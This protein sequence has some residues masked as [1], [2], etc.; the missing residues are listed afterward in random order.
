MDI[1][2]DTKRNHR[3]AHK[4]RSL[5]FSR[6]SMDPNGTP[7]VR[8]EGPLGLNGPTHGITMAP[9]WYSNGTH[10]NISMAPTLG[11]QWPPWAPI[12]DF[13]DRLCFCNAFVLGKSLFL[14]TPDI[15]VAVSKIAIGLAKRRILAINCSNYNFK[16]TDIQFFKK[17]KLKK[18]NCKKET[19]RYSS[20]SC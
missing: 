16:K 5:R 17:I 8:W 12:S 9:T 3:G 10:H 11:S 1:R 13:V 19:I 20:C 4:R 18:R 2:K 15:R 6:E 7:R 14:Q